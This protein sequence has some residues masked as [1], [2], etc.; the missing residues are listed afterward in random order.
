MLGKA[1]SV[2]L[3]ILGLYILISSILSIGKGEATSSYHIGCYEADNSL[4]QG[5]LMRQYLFN[6]S[7]SLSPWSVEEV[8]RAQALVERRQVNPEAANGVAL[9]FK[10]YII[11]L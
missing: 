8:R 1:F 11:A 9:E 2:A 6:V 5:H 10:K 7:Q 4:D 3:I